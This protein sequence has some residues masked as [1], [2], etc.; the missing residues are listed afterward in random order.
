[1]SNYFLVKIPKINIHMHESRNLKKLCLTCCAAKRQQSRAPHR[2]LL[3]KDYGG[4]IGPYGYKK[5][6]V[7]RAA[8][9][10]WWARA[11]LQS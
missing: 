7:W 4:L 2:K 9:P 5:N 3:T 1:M 6:W 8:S 11:G 10:T